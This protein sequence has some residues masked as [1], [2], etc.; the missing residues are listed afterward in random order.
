MKVVSISLS[1]FL[2]FCWTAY[3]RAYFFSRSELIHKAEVI[4]VIDLQAPVKALPTGQDQDPFGGDVA[5]GKHWSYAK[6]ANARV[7][8]VLKG[9]ISKNFILYGNESFICAQCRLSK[10]RFLAF[11]RKDGDLW[12]GVNWNFSLRP[13]RGEQVE[14]YVSDEQRYPMKFFKTE[15]VV[16][17]IR[18]TLELK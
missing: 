6:Q 13:I 12:S 7:V 17:M 4:A 1:F 15:D 2:A 5:E 8:Q 10:G 9:K 16:A 18:K 3:G 14:W 11:L